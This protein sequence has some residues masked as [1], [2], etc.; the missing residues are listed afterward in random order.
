MKYLFNQTIYFKPDLSSNEEISK[1]RKQRFLSSMC[2]IWINLLMLLMACNITDEDRLNLAIRGKNLFEVKQLVEK[3]APIN[4]D[5]SN[6]CPILVAIEQ[7]TPEIAQ[8]LVDQ[9]ANVNVV[10]DSGV[11]PILIA[12]QKEDEQML[13]VLINSPGFIF[14]TGKVAGVTPMSYVEIIKNKNIKA[15]VKDFLLKSHQLPIT[16]QTKLDPDGLF[17]GFWNGLITPFKFVV[18][19]FQ[20][21]FSK[22]SEGMR[23]VSMNRTGFTYWFGYVPGLLFGLSFVMQFI[24]GRRK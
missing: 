5:C 2:L 10:N 20:S 3:G 12:L 19:L 7:G 13:H 11:S 23:Y 8:Y 15:M 24:F 1:Y 18:S 17:T 6:F 9:K 21:I 4:V 22:N 16:S 14:Q